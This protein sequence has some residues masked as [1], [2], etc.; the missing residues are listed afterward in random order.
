VNCDG[1]G[2]VAR[3]RLFLRIETGVGA[4]IATLA[5]GAMARFETGAVRGER[6][7]RRRHRNGFR[8]PQRRAG[9]S[10]CKRYFG[11]FSAHS[12]IPSMH[13]N[14]SAIVIRDFLPRSRLGLMHGLGGSS[15]APAGSGSV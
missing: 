12:M 9:S 8:R 6:I 4:P 1:C 14:P 7:R 10:F 3:G 11:P 2:V 15:Y 5:A 13:Q